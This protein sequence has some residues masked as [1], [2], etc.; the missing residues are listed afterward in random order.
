LSRANVGRAWRRALRDAKVRAVP[1]HS[2]RHGFATM[3][4]QA[5]AHPRVMQA[6]LG[7]TTARVSLEV[8][9]HVAETDLARAA[10]RLGDQAISSPTGEGADPTEGISWAPTASERMPA[11]SPSTTKAPHLQGFLEWSIAD[12]NR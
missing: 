10:R 11:P 6:L 5:G 7:H 12:S 2:L 8:Y 1:C 3:L 4:A 9:S